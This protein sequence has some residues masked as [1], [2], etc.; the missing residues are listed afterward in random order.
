MSI[1]N[2]VSDYENRLSS[3]HSS[4]AQVFRSVPL[5]RLSVA[6]GGPPQATSFVLVQRGR[7]DPSL[8]T[9]TPVAP[10][11]IRFLTARPDGESPD[12]IWFH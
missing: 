11:Q 7:N 4:P 1:Q 8:L 9:D 6:L 5:V 2:L 12:I 3:A 10:S